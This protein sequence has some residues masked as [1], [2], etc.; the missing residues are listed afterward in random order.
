MDLMAP[1]LNKA[2][3][4]VKAQMARDSAKAEANN[5]KERD[6]AALEKQR[7]VDLRGPLTLVA[8]KE[9]TRGSTFRADQ[10]RAKLEKQKKAQKQE[11]RA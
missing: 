10:A 8:S 3:V 1:N 5:K 11:R 4:Q 6:R 9:L 2:K 7:C